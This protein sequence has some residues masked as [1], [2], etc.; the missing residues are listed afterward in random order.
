M[1]AIRLGLEIEQHFASSG[2]TLK[3]MA[4]VVHFDDDMGFILDSSIPEGLLALCTHLE[5]APFVV[6]PAIN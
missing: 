1:M 4:V 3:R 2:F 5:F 6:L